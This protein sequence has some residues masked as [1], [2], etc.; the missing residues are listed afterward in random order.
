[1]SYLAHLLSI[2]VPFV[3]LAAVGLA[4]VH[5]RRTIATALAALG[6]SLA[7]IGHVTG[8]L[9]GYFAF[10]GTGN[11]AS[12]AARFGWTFPVTHWGILSGV[13]VGSL[14]LLWYALREAPGRV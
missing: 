12:A 10:D 7:A 1:V 14:S 8:A 13:W 9:V 4:L 11:F 2:V 6:F 3:A 5:R